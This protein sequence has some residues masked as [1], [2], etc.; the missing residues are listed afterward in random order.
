MCGQSSNLFALPRESPENSIKARG[1]L[2]QQKCSRLAAVQRLVANTENSPLYQKNEIHEE[3][4]PQ[5]WLSLSLFTWS[6]MLNILLWLL[7]SEIL[8]HGAVRN[9]EPQSH[10]CDFPVHQGGLHILRTSKVTHPV[11]REG[12][13]SCTAVCALSRCFNVKG[14]KAGYSQRCAKCCTG[15]FLPYPHSN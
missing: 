9:A 15:L 1:Q 4:W 10:A 14:I 12:S 6:G 5:R 3:H 11:F 7:Q 2:G 8:P 13:V